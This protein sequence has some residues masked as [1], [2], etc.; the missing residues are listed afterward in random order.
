MP[1][2]AKR[3]GKK[4]APAFLGSTAG[5]ADLGVQ[6]A[7]DGPVNRLS[8]ASLARPLEMPHGEYRKLAIIIAIAVAISAALIVAYNFT[9]MGDA[10]KTRAQV[11]EVIN[12]GVE[13][14]LP[15]LE[16]YAGLKNDEMFETF[17][18][19][20]YT[21]FDNS[22]DEDRNVDGFDV[23]KIA[24]DLDPDVAAAAYADGL[25]NMG[26]VD[27]AR[28]LL[29]S[30]RFIVSR[31]N[32]AELRLRYADFD[33]TDAKE[34]IAAAIESQGF[35][36]ADIADIAEDTMGNK[37]LSGTFEK[38]KKKY[39]YTISACDLSQVYEIEGAPENAQFVGIRVN[40]AN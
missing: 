36:D 16:D 10:E 25:E 34:A 24:S 22:N 7:S 11:M 23:F 4:E 33:S 38:G 27:Q 18:K 9:V 8:A 37:N 21:I 29:G 39:E 28:Y 20:G 19:N 12:R 30:W 40:V 6:F 35:E 17:K 2:Q 13:L 3:N 15:K 32:D 14:E 26:P 1:R 5:N 31:V